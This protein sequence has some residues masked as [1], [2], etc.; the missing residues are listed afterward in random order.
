MKADAQLT[1]RP[2]IMS[3][4]ALTDKLASSDEFWDLP[5]KGFYVLP[6]SMDFNPKR[7][8]P[9]WASEWEAVEKLR[10]SKG[11]ET[12]LQGEYD[13]RGVA[14]SELASCAYYE[15]AR[16]CLELCLMVEV[17]RNQLRKPDVA[18]LKVGDTF[19]IQMKYPKITKTPGTTFE[20]MVLVSLAGCAGFP[21]ASWQALEPHDKK[22]VIDLKG[23]ALKIHNK[24]VAR[25]HPMLTVAGIEEK[26]TSGKTL[27]AWTKAKMPEN[28]KNLSAERQ[29]KNLWS[30]FM[31]L[32]LRYP[33]DLI[34]TEFKKWLLK[35]HPK[36]REPKVERRGRNSARDK[37]NA[38]GAMRLR[39]YCHTLNEAQNL[40]LPLRNTNNGLYYSDRTAWNRACLKS[41]EYFHDLL[42]LPDSCLPIHF[43]K[44]WQK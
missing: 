36:A 22:Q 44:G 3:D 10:K 33:P 34:I 29:R 23:Q 41:V 25:E 19:R 15:Y 31:M 27:S 4:F 24:E 38:L 16:E 35:H 30:G 40:T 17:I 32:N 14:E 43:S 2:E 13:F 9:S 5:E 1:Q 26:Q 11:A 8:Q 28:Y 21:R 7:I 12:L 37:L 20:S 39:F 18:D 42:D 6:V